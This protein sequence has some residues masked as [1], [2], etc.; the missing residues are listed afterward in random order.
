M[1]WTEEKIRRLK[2][3]W[4]AGDSASA[5]GRELGVTKNSV[6]GKSRRLGLPARPSPIVKAKTPKSSS[7]KAG[8]RE[9]ARISDVFLLDHNMCRWPFGNPDEKGFYFCCKAVAPG[10]PYCEEHCA[11]AYVTKSGSRERAS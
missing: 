11:T 8:S 9:K 5:I 6:I 7:R 3:M 10:K 1:T 2:D 4:D